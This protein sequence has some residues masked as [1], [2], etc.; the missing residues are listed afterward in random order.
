MNIHPL[1]VVLPVKNSLDSTLQTLE[2]IVKAD[3]QQGFD[4]TLYDDFSDPEISEELDK[5]ALQH[6]FNIVHLSDVT[7]N[8]SPNYRLVLQ[9]AQSK[10][11]TLGAHIIIVESDVEVEKDTFSELSSYAESLEKPGLV[12]AVT[13]DAEGAINYPYLYASKMKTGVV[14]TRKRLSFCCTLLSNSFLTAFDFVLLNPNKS[15]YDVFISHKATSMGFQNYLIT[16]SRVLHKPHSSRP[17]KLLKYSNPVKYYWR[18]FTQGLD[19]I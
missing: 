10:A 6:G 19:K 12:A 14:P 7:T 5:V 1:H 11:L 16:S 3:K 13:V 8:P 15:W 2:A 4:L 9:M 17:W 18:K